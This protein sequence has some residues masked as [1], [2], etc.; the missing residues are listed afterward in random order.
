MEDGPEEPSSSGISRITTIIATTNRMFKNPRI[1]PISARL[2]PEEFDADADASLIP[3]KPRMIAG[4]AV[5]IGHMINDST[6]QISEA[7]ATA[8]TDGGLG[9]T[10]GAT[11]AEAL[12]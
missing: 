7:I 11:G 10:D 1:R 8:D 4:M 3:M 2:F 5:T 9:A 12:E 6:P